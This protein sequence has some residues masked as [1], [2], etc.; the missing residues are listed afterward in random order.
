MTLV[1]KGTVGIWGEL[2]ENNIRVF[3][4]STK[5]NYHPDTHPDTRAEQGHVSADPNRAPPHRTKWTRE[6]LILAVVIL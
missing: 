5:Q 2:Q 1:R 4:L 6:A 3:H